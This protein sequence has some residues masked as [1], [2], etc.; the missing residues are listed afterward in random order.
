MS[1]LVRHVSRVC[2]SI[3]F[4]LTSGVNRNF[5]IHEALQEILEAFEFEGVPA[6]S[7]SH[8]NGLRLESGILSAFHDDTLCAL[9]MACEIHRGVKPARYKYVHLCKKKI[10]CLCAY[11]DNLIFGYV[12]SVTHLIQCR[13][14]ASRLRIREE[15]LLGKHEL[16][17]GRTHVDA[18]TTGPGIEIE[19]RLQ[20]TRTFKQKSYYLLHR[21][22]NRSSR[23]QVPVSASLAPGS[24]M[25]PH[26]CPSNINIHIDVSFNQ[27]VISIQLSVGPVRSHV[28]HVHLVGSIE[29]LLRGDILQC[30]H[31]PGDVL[32]V[33]K[34]QNLTIT[35]FGHTDNGG[36]Q[37]KGPIQLLALYGN[38]LEQLLLAELIY[39]TDGDKGKLDSTEH[40]FQLFAC[41]KCCVTSAE[42]FG[43]KYVVMGG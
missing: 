43:R 8:Y 41:L 18:A 24:I 9:I 16:I 13:F 42:R 4:Q 11:V 21:L 14:N 5:K 29:S 17:F 6:D 10:K 34:D 20:D 40:I 23:F 28:T 2:Y 35:G 19:Q 39:G 12:F 33:E 25:K 30:P 38:K 22:S 15:V 26:Y 27:D 32:R 1:T 37:G 7:A 31:D 3:M 36:Q